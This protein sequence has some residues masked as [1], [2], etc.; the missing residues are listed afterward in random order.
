[1]L[2]TEKSE[3]FFHRFRRR[4]DRTRSSR[5][6]SFVTSSILSRSA[7]E[8]E[9]SISTECSR[10]LEVKGH[11]Y[12]I[13]IDVLRSVFHVIPKY[14]CNPHISFLPT[15]K[16]MFIVAFRGKEKAATSEGVGGRP[17]FFLSISVSESRVSQTFSI[18]KHLDS[19]DRS[20]GPSVDRA[21]ISL[22]RSRRLLPLPPPSAMEGWEGGSCDGQT[23][24]VGAFVP[25][26]HLS[27]ARRS[28]NWGGQICKAAFCDI[29]QSVG[30][31]VAADAGMS[32][33][34]QEGLLVRRCR[35]RLTRLRLRRRHQR[36]LP[37]PSPPPSS[38]SPVTKG[39][40]APDLGSKSNVVRQ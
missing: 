22:S 9:Q 11:L 32:S 31:P 36:L 19:I 8:A 35:R 34:Q 3:F 20:V 40:A 13:A 14:M 7:N 12:R 26:T 5:S 39:H 10:K 29:R 16:P 24:V 4:R 33:A 37:L 17:S 1:M 18:L 30:V 25:A 21:L 23:L 38:F 28:Q 27:R 6:S 2:S 15:R